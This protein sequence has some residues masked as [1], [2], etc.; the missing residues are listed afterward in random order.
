[1]TKPATQGQLPLAKGTSLDLEAFS[2]HLD[3]GGPVLGKG[4]LGW[5]VV[6]SCICYTYN[7]SG[8]IRPHSIY[9]LLRE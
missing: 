3:S 2:S 1:M 6:T 8:S 9:Q 7:V 4:D 5:R